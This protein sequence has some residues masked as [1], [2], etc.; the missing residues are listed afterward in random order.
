MQVLTGRFSSLFEVV[1]KMMM[2]F[3]TRFFNVPRVQS[4]LLVVVPLGI[5][6][7]LMLKA[8]RARVFG[9]PH[10]QIRSG[11]VQHGFM[12]IWGDFLPS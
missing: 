6:V 12:Q 9:D 11:W 8:H 1:W 5:V 10:L 3:F 2:C 4:V 7:F